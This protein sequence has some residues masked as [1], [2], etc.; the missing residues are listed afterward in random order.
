MLHAE[1]LVILSLTAGGGLI[2]ALRVEL[3]SNNS[4]TDA[5]NEAFGTARVDSASP[6]VSRL[7]LAP[8]VCSWSA[9]LGKLQ[10]L[11]RQ[12]GPRTRGVER[13]F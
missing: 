10:G 5:C 13:L 12:A 3:A 4:N 7:R 1:V 6:G 8:Y 9:K 2:V 11:E